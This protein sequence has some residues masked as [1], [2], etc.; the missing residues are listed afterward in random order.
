MPGGEYS[1][2]DKLLEEVDEP[3]TIEKRRL[4]PGESILAKRLLAIR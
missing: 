4:L 3:E 2:S 1:V